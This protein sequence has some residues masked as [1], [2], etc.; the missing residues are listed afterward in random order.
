[1]NLAENR[2]P[3]EWSILDELF[4]LTA[5]KHKSTSCASIVIEGIIVSLLACGLFSGFGKN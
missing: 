3:K 4:S 5:R 2:T 1:M